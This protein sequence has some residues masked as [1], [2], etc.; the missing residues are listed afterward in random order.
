MDGNVGGDGNAGAFAGGIAATPRGYAMS[1]KIMLTAIV[2]LFSAVL[3][4][5]FLHLYAR[6]YLLRRNSARRRRRGL[7]FAQDQAPDA[8]VRGLEPAVR[9]SLP[10]VVFTEDERV[11]GIE[12]A[13]CL[14]EVVEGEKVRILPKCGHGF[15]IECID[16]WFGSHATCPL[17]RAA[18]ELVSEPA[19]SSSTCRV[20]DG[21]STSEGVRVETSAR[22]GA[23]EETGSKSPR[24]TILMLR[25]LW[26]RDLSR[27]RGGEPA[28]VLDLER[29]EGVG[30]RLD[31][32]S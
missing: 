17:C 31:V 20:E 13:V 14:S 29:G 8:A 1:G 4:V 25:R 10:V 26:S 7:S 18:V 2:A 23:D 5:L 32:C 16:M 30:A 6:W 9:K 11:D 3:A 21:P 24:S 22:R 19:A 12:C 28:A 15:H 27:F